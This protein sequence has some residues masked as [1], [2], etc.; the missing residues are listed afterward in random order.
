MSPNGLGWILILTAGWIAYFYIST[1]M[2]RLEPIGVD[3]KIR[4][5]GETEYAELERTSW[6]LLKNYESLTREKSEDWS[7][8]DCGEPNGEAFD[9]CWHCNAERELA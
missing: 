9:V 1:Q 6:E 7:C 5:D 3:E 8:P 4:T 2:I